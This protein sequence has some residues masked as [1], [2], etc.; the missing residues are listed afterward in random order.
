MRRRGFT[1]IEVMLALVI[2]GVVVTLG[3]STLQAGMDVERRITSARNSDQHMTVMRAL[4][5][6]ALRHAVPGDAV[7]EHRMRTVPG[8]DGTTAQLA[9]VSRGIVTPHGGTAPWF[10][11][12]TT[13]SAGVTMDARAVD[14]GAAPLRL[15]IS[16]ARTF[17]VRFKAREDLD[18]QPTWD[19]AARLPLAIEVR[20]LARDGRDAVAPVVA[21]TSPVGAA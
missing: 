21:R 3:Y 10:V 7:A 18:W 1:L 5:G 2:S 19:D 9:F 4:L 11:T 20:F 16:D 14:A 13:D 12:L 17:V 15:R 8:V 6:D